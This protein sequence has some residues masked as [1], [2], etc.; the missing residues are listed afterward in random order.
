MRLTTRWRATLRV[1]SFKAAV[2]RTVCSGGGGGRGV[3]IGD[4]RSLVEEPR[5]RDVDVLVVVGGGG[6]LVELRF[7]VV[8]RDRKS[9]ESVSLGMGYGFS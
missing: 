6:V 9:E 5:R 1:R 7:A 8:L 2:I 4:S 3:K